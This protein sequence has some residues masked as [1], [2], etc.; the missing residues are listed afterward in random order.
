MV[1]ETPD[2]SVSGLVSPRAVLLF[3]APRGAAIAEDK[4]NPA[5]YTVYRQSLADF[6]VLS[7][8]LALCLSL[9]ICSSN[10]F[11]R[12][13]A[14]KTIAPI[15]GGPSPPTTTALLVARRALIKQKEKKKFQGGERGNN[16]RMGTDVGVGEIFLLTTEL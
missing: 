6:L 14:S 15:M 5:R 10:F 13:L 4:K 7:Q 9:K 12:I 16:W 8:P 3:R 1:G 11:S 2:T